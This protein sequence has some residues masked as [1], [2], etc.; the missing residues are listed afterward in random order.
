MIFRNSGRNHVV[1]QSVWGEKKFPQVKIEPSSKDSY[2]FAGDPERACETIKDI[3]KIKMKLC[4]IIDTGKR[5]AAMEMR[6]RKY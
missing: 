6:K 5:L 1:Y 2:R 3:Y 4:L